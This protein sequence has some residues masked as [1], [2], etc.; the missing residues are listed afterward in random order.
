MEIF[1]MEK[2]FN[3]LM[4]K[5]QELIKMLKENQ[6]KKVK[7]WKPN[8]CEEY[9]FIQND[10]LLYRYSDGWKN[11]VSDKGRYKLGN[12]FK[13]EEQA[14]KELDRRIAECELLD[15]ADGSVNDNTWFEIEYTPYDGRFTP[16]QY[17]TVTSSCFRFATEESCKKAIKLLGTERLKLIF[18]ID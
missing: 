8:K 9:W 5:G 13:T 15:L 4:K 14:Q 6:S 11:G 12:C 18:R 2:E 3:E 7:R 1:E 17:S 10:G 16:G